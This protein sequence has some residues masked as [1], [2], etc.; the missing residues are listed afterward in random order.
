MLIIASRSIEWTFIKKPLRKYELQEGQDTPVERPLSVANVLL[1]ALDLFFNQ[2]GIGWSWSSQPFPRE[3]TPPS[4][5]LVLAKAFLKFTVFD[6]SHYILYLVL[7][8][9]DEKGVGSLFDVS[10]PFLPRPVSILLVTFLGGLWVCAQLELLY[11]AAM[12][13]GRILL[14][15]PASH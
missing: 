3:N 12:L 4:I 8:S 2:R 1:D 9:M 7:P 6:T 15:Q 13:I 14:R 11:Y 5:P 10:L